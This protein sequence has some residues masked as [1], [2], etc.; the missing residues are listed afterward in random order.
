MYNNSKYNSNHVSVKKYSV[1][2]IK[3]QPK[4]PKRPFGRPLPIPQNWTF[5]IFQ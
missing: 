5:L 1:K 3:K 4:P 2:T